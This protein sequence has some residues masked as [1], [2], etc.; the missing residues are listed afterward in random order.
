MLDKTRVQTFDSKEYPLRLGNCWHVVMTT[1]PRANP[2][3]PDEKMHMHKLDSVSILIREMENGHREVKVLLGDKE[4]KFVP[5]STQPQILVNE[6]LVKV[7]KDI[8]WQE[9][10]GDE[11]LYEIFLIG[12]YSV[13]LVSDEYELNLVYDG[14]RIMIKVNNKV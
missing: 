7:T 3:N 13:G 14:K 4:V 8:S 12:D 6:Q 9:R 10:N 2:D 5:T 1:Y 11:V